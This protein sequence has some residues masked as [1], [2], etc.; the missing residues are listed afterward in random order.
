MKYHH[1]YNEMQ[2][3]NAVFFNIW[4][5]LLRFVTPIAI[6]IVFISGLL[7]ECSLMDESLLNAETGECSNPTYMQ[8]RV[9]GGVILAIAYIAI[10]VKSLKK[11]ARG[12]SS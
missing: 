9:I 8:P 7:P 5:V 12:L 2:V 4:Y 1:V 11:P 6:G 10:V 3:K